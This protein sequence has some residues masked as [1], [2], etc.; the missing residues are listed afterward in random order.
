VPPDDPAALAAAIVRF[1]TET[2]EEAFRAGAAEEKLG[3]S[4]EP[5]VTAIEEMADERGD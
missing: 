5:M 4:W 3:Y 2:R 1:Y